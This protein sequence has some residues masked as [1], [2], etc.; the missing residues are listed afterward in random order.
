MSRR[1]A[2]VGRLRGSIRAA[3]EE[4]RHDPEFVGRVVSAVCE[5]VGL[6]KMASMYLASKLKAKIK[7]EKAA[8]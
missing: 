1:D 8:A 7:K 6:D 5:E 3:L 4:V 2:I